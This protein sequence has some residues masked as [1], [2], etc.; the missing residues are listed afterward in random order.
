MPWAILSEGDAIFEVIEKLESED[1]N[2]LANG[3]SSVA[4]T[5]ETDARSLEADPAT[6]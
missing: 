3:V 6:T 1:S 4:V 5:L 2:S